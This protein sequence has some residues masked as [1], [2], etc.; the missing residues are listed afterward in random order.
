MD[1][2]DFIQVISNVKINRIDNWVV[3]LSF[4][5]DLICLIICIYIIKKFI[6]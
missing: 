6:N 2:E 4:I 5:W 1:N 3:L